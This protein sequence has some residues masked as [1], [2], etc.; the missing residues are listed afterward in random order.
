MKKIFKISLPIVFLFFTS[1]SDIKK[2]LGFEKDVPNEFLIRQIN[3]IER[4]PNYDLL[5]PD[6]QVK[7]KKNKKNT[8]SSNTKSMIEESL[9]GNGKGYSSNPENAKSSNIEESVLKQIGN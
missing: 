9:K 8:I 2:G 7:N 4:P 6:S 5:P 1:C 3:P